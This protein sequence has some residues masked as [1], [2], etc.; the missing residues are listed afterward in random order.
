M[1]FRRRLPSVIKLFGRFVAVELAGAAG[2]AG[3]AGAVGAASAAVASSSVFADATAVV[4]LAADG[5]LRT[6]FPPTATH[7]PPHHWGRCNIL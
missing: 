7:C 1:S 3:A 4:A 2:S 6:G 5:V